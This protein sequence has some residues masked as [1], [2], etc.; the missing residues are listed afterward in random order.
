MSDSDFNHFDDLMHKILGNVLDVKERLVR[1]ETR[2][3]LLAKAVGH[4]KILQLED[5]E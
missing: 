1:T 4:E 5:N 3:V 2:L